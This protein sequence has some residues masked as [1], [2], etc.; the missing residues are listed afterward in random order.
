MAAITLDHLGKRYP[1]GVTALD[2]LCLSIADGE[3]LVLLGP[4]GSGKTSTLHLLAGL[5]APTSGRILIDG[6]DVTSLP[7]RRRDV[8]LVFQRPALYPHLSA[9]DNMA[10]GERLRQGGL[11]AWLARLAGRA[12]SRRQQ[13]AELA[14]RVADAAARLGLEGLL[15]RRPAALSGGQQQRVALGRALVRRPRAFLL[16]E[17]LSSLDPAQRQELRRELHLLQRRLGATMLH[18]THDQ[19]EALALGDRV[20]VLHQ[21]RLQQAASPVDLYRRPANRFVAGFLGWPPMNLVDGELIRGRTSGRLAFCTAAAIWQL[22]FALEMALGD[23]PAR[24]VTLGFRPEHVRLRPP[25]SL[26]LAPTSPRLRVVL[27]ESTGRDRLVTLAGGGW[28]VIASQTACATMPAAQEG[29]QFEVEV[30]MNRVTLFER[31]G[32]RALAHGEPV[33]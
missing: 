25:G 16:D 17:P 23:D 22:P 28:H 29:Q 6:R 14:A 19:V 5:E 7:P 8:A 15:D 10:F 26:D 12:P 2:D 4:S 20:A 31:P 13:R 27:V 24:E 33:G 9:R 11:D 21:G 30:D 3:L 32:G 1:G 18:V